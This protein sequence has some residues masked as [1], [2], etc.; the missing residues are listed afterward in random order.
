MLVNKPFWKKI[1]L[2]L[3]GLV[4]I[5]VVVGGYFVISK[6]DK[7][8]N[9]YVT[10]SNDTSRGFIN[11][12][13]NA[14]YNGARVLLTPGFTHKEPIV[15]SF[16][17]Y[18]DF[19][20]DT[21]FMLFDETMNANDAGAHN[22]WSITFRSDLGSIQTGIAMCMLLN[23]YQDVFLKNDGKLSYGIYGGLPFS[24]VT[25]FMGGVQHGVKWFNDNIAT[26]T[27]TIDGKSITY[28]PV[29]QIKSDIG[30][31]VGG[32]GPSQ[33]LAIT[34]HLITKGIDI[35]MP[36]AGPQ[37]WTAM[38][39]IIK[40]NYKCLLIGVDSAMEDDPLNKK[41]NFESSEGVIGNGKYVQFSSVKD[42]ANATDKILQI[43]NNGNIIPNVPSS[44]TD[45]NDR[46][47]YFKNFS[48]TGAEGEVSGFGT[49]AVGDI[50]NGCVGVSNSG[51]QYL[52]EA[53]KISGSTDPAFDAKYSEISNMIFTGSDGQIYN[54]GE[55]PFG[56]S[57][58]FNNNFKGGDRSKILNIKGFIQKGNQNNANK[59]KVAISSSTSVLID[60][61]FSQ[62]C[63]MGLA[64]F[65]KSM[66]INIP[67]PVPILTTYDNRRIYG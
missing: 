63:Y 21:G 44:I 58:Q 51:K 2:A 4:I 36:V 67:T 56:L 39:Q 59:I 43:V 50:S 3:G 20:K 57:Q 46:A 12:Y 41:I 5:G 61:S 60:S 9:Y 6:L 8:R 11:S 19:F 53:L 33:G 22:T 17:E 35:L 54:Y 66:N 13:K 55:K 29:E 26:K 16:T 25:S 24:S 37:V 38:D 30:D 42:L 15:Q 1:W 49:C 28:E 40:L 64:I 18:Y 47:N 23:K 52:E 62:S 14:I 27:F 32:F 48:E 31:F 65:L 45:P 7:Y 10:P 34:N